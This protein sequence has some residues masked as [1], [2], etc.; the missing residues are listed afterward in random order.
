VALDELDRRLLNL[1]QEELPLEPRPY[2][3]VA[4]AARLSEREALARVDRLLMG[5]VIRQI[6]PI[7]D[8]R[9]LG[10]ASTLVAATV[11][12]GRVR[13]AASVIN[14]HPGVSHNY[15][16][17]HRL[18]MWFTI[19]V[20]PDS[21]LGLDRT[22]DVLRELSGARSMRKL[23]TLRRFK[24]RV[25][26]DMDG[27]A[28]AL[29]RPDAAGAEQA[30]AEPAG[31][32]PA[33]AEPAGACDALDMAVVRATQGDMP[34]IAKPYAPAA[35]RL[36]MDTGEL[37][38]HM[39]GMRARGQL[40][41]VAA[42]L[43]HRK[44]GFTANGMGVWRVPAERILELGPQMACFRGVSHCYERPTY[45]DW[46]YSIFTMVH[47]RSRAECEAVMAAIAERTG[48]HERAVLY[49]STELKKVRLRYFTDE[50][51]L[52][53]RRHAGV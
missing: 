9:A 48:I 11:D 45:E 53:E 35:E 42:I 7:Y 14:A 16:R 43:S 19:A 17:N 33:D 44:A 38:E 49:S 3:A 23:P 31:A 25:N 46:P 15:I 28:E 2:A 12:D 24:I 10:Y 29:T 40:R 39:R 5:G 37:L 4:D 18:N 32:A 6:G 13:R 20:A 30:G 21:A 41:R 34:A 47:G 52:W 36:Q 51:R 27:D 8:T 22:L 1:M 26:L 50:L